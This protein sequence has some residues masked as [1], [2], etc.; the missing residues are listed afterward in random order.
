MYLFIHT[1][2]YAPF[3]GPLAWLVLAEEL[4]LEEWTGRIGNHY[5]QISQVTKKN[6]LSKWTEL[7]RIG[8]FLSHRGTPMSS[9]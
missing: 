1:R 2:M 6:L 3:V 4:E 7:C 9:I 5:F 8:G